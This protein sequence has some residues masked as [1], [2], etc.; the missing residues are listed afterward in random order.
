MRWSIGSFRALANDF[1]SMR[2]AAAEPW[3]SDDRRSRGFPA[4]H[5]RGVCSHA[6]CPVPSVGGAHLAKRDEE[7]QRRFGALVLIH[8]IDVKAVTTTARRGIVKRL[9]QL[10]LAQK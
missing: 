6:C 1:V 4:C 2:G 3:H 9:L 7:R 10:V 8:S 5:L